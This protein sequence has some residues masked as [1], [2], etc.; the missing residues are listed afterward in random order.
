MTDSGCFVWF[1]GFVRTCVTHPH[2]HTHKQKTA[3]DPRGWMDISQTPLY[4]SRHAAPAPRRPAR[5]RWLPP[6]AALPAAADAAPLRTADAADAAP[7]WTAA[8]DDAAAGA[9]A[10][11]ALV[12]SGPVSNPP[13]R[14]RYV[15]LRRLCYV[16]AV[17][18]C[19]VLCVRKGMGGRL[20]CSVVPVGSARVVVVDGPPNPEP[21]ITD[22][23]W[24][25][26]S[27][28][29]HPP[30]PTPQHTTTPH[31]GT[32]VVQYRTVA[33]GEKTPPAVTRKFQAIDDGNCSP[34]YLRATTYYVPGAFWIWVCGCG[35]V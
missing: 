20:F 16:C 12:A 13:P 1:L 10:G 31:T 33:H 11:H 25:I 29:H 32:E 21:R 15:A 35:G 8:A 18:C 5:A 4:Q 17:L 28:S 6:A 23:L 26:H 24:T 22:L 27:S 14:G 9:G 7:L 34:R 30:A 3:H 19:V 2:T